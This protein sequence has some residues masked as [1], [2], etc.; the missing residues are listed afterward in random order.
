MNAPTKPSVQLT[1]DEK[2]RLVDAVYAAGRQVTIGDIAKR[3]GLGIPNTSLALNQL[4]YDS[5]ARIVVDQSGN[6]A[7]AFKHGFERKRRTTPFHIFFYAWSALLRMCSLLLKSAFGVLL[8]V[9][10]GFLAIPVLIFAT[11]KTVWDISRLRDQRAESWG[12]LDLRNWPYV[13]GWTR[14]TRIDHAGQS[15][16]SNILLDCFSF[17]FGE[18]DP[19]DDLEQRRWQ[20]IAQ[21]IERNNGV[22]IWEQIAPFS[23]YRSSED[24]MIPVMVHFD[25]S[26]EVTDSGQLV[27]VFPQ[28]MISASRNTNKEKLEPKPDIDAS[29][30]EDSDNPVFLQERFW[31]ATG[32]SRRS[33]FLIVGLALFNVLAISQF[34]FWLVKS[35][36]IVLTLLMP[37]AA[38]FQIFH[39][40]WMLSVL[41][42]HVGVTEWYVFCA[43]LASFMVLPYSF[44]FLVYPMFRIGWE[45]C[46]NFGISSRNRQ[47]EKYA[48]LLTL[49]APDLASKLAEA[50]RRSLRLTAVQEHRTVFDSARDSLEQQF[51]HI[52]P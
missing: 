42:L 40:G 29:Q 17:V 39:L 22:L 45:Q 25:G 18:G 21:V 27:Y 30:K 31:K 3:T 38:A 16:T 13:L 33:K 1:R 15:R 4:A 11:A 6:V 12:L 48:Q 28:M 2:T 50:G 44:F 7:Y 32:I 19:N 35:H 5:K 49:P 36:L 14:L 46:K 8:F 52:E 26:P 24:D 41:G 34:L 47:R 43:T 51:D 23:G 9:S 20:Q 10:V 37:I